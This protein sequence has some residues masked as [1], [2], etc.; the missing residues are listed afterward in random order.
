M[1]SPRYEF[2]TKKAI[3]IIMK[4]VATVQGIKMRSMYVPIELCY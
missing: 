1:Q 2:R 3:V 4:G